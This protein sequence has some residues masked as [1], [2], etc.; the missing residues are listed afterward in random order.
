M[1]KKSTV[2]LNRQACS[3]VQE[4]GLDL[5]ASF[6]VG[7]PEETEDDIR[8]TFDFIKNL[9]CNSMGCGNFRP[10]PGSPFYFEFLERQQIDKK[11]IDWS[12]L[13]NF[14]A[15][16]EYIFCKLSK[17]RL[18]E[19]F[20]EGAHLAYA[21]QYIGVHEDVSIGEQALLSDMAKSQKVK[22]FSDDKGIFYDYAGHERREN[23]FYKI[24]TTL[25]RG[26]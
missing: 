1:N 21:N 6:M 7:V 10:L 9:N 25:G 18:M 12:N 19:L 26:K 3:Y 20:K 24:L 23:W 16:P 4:A 22:I 5:G 13:G 11:S 2:E 14:S 15:E 8:Q 17:D